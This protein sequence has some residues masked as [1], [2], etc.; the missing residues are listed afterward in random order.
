MAGDFTSRSAFGNGGIEIALLIVAEQVSN[1]VG[2]PILHAV[3]C[4]LSV[5]LKSSG[6]GLDG[7]GF[8]ASRILGA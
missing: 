2:Q 3:L 4:L 8:H 6:E 1:A 5:G 7:F